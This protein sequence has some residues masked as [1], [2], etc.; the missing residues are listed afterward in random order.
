LGRNRRERK[1]RQ[2]GSIFDPNLQGNAEI[3]DKIHG[4]GS[5]NGERCD[6]ETTLSSFES[7][8]RTPIPNLLISKP[9]SGVWL[10]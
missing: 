4:I 9:T 2:G 5:E 6:L 10:N 7:L 3:E 1:W 8:V